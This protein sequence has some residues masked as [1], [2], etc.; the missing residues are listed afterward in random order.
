MINQETSKDQ[1]R[2]TYLIFQ[3]PYLLLEIRI[4]TETFE[5]IKH[6]IDFENCL[7]LLNMHTKPQLQKLQY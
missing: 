4:S 3:Q 6:L 7:K 1:L 5:R 2:S